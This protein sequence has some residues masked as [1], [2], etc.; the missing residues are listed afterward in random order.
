MPLIIRGG[1]AAI[2]EAP[3]SFAINASH[4]LSTASKLTNIAAIMSS[5]DKIGINKTIIARNINTRERKVKSQERIM[6]HVKS[7]FGC[8]CVCWLVSGVESLLP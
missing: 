8:L 6:F 7:S 4:A 5:R 2:R 1:M 3:T